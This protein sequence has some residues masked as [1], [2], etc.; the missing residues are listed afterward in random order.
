MT[1]ARVRSAVLLA[2]AVGGL[3]LVDLSYP[4]QFFDVPFDAS[5]AH[6][7]TGTLL[8]VALLARDRLWLVA[9]VFG[10]LVVWQWKSQLAA[11][12]L[13][14]ALAGVLAMAATWAL[15][16][17]AAAAIGWPARGERRDFGFVAL[18]RVVVVG[19]VLLPV[20]I[21]LAWLLLAW[22]VLDESPSTP[23]ALSGAV[24]T[25]LAK[26]FGTLIVTLPLVV[27]GTAA[28][29]AESSV[30]DP[31]PI[32][33]PAL[34]VGA[35][36]PMLIAGW[37]GAS[38]GRDAALAIFVDYRLIVGGALLA[39]V[40][41][42]PL[43]ASM[44]LLMAAQSVFAI[45][46]ADEAARGRDL[47]DAFALLRAAFELAVMQLL[48]LGAHV[49]HRDRS[50]NLQAL[51]EANAALEQR[52]QE[53][54]RFVMVASHDLQEPL[55]KIMTFGDRVR[56]EP[57]SQLSQR[58]VDDL[59]R[60]DR[61]ARRMR[62]LIDGLLDYSRVST[63]PV[64]LQPVALAEV[65]AD[66]RED[67]AES[68]E[69]C[70]AE[71][72]VG[73]MPTISADPV[74]MRQLLQNLLGNALRYR[75]P[76]R[77]PRIAISAELFDDALGRRCCR[78]RVAD[79]GIGFEPEQAERIFGLFQRLHDREKIEGTGLGLTIVRRIAEL[80]QGTATASGR[81]GEGAEFVIT[82]RAR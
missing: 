44:T 37:I 60:M 25:V 53:L 82:L 21:G 58:Q 2:F 23:I 74:Q 77:R 1:R 34:A 3:A 15:L 68:I 57:G 45:G 69:T 41:A 12:G 48:V 32:E 17:V 31:P 70:A 20:T 22:G 19:S 56:G 43:R 39:A 47:A 10:N 51:A 4:A 24:Q 73:P 40:I 54:Q 59:E 52:N 62:A 7:H 46:L 49:Y 61:S 9:A 8:A 16:R 72:D 28:R 71:I 79:N 64:T 35:V 27:L 6:L 76:L 55:R 81:P 36:L 78:L 33:W 50:R 14:S 66:V 38:Q 11:P 67:L 75:S 65:V 26:C 30:D 18:I 5:L 42:L 13:Q 29:R 80:H 63:R